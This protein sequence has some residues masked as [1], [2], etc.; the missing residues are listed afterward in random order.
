MLLSLLLLGAPSLV[1]IVDVN[2]IPMDREGVLEHQTV[3]VRGSRIAA[4][5]P[6]G[7]TQVPA[8]ATR[9]SG[10]GKY[11]MPGLVD[12][13][14]HLYSL[15]ELKMNLV[16]GI[17]T[18]YNL[19]GR[20]AH[21]A[22]RDRITKGQL[23]GPTIVTCGP[24]IYECDTAADAR[25]RVEAMAKRGYDA[26]KIYNDVS[27]EAFPALIESARSRH[28]LVVGHIPRAPGFDDTLKY[29]VPIAHA[30]EFL[31][32]VFNDGKTGPDEIPAVAKRTVDA[33]VSVTA[34]LVT[35]DHI[36]RQASDLKGLLARPATQ[37]LAP[38]R[39]E[40]WQ[41][42]VN[43]YEQRFKDPKVQ[44]KLAANLRFQKALIREIHKIGGVVL[45]GTDANCPGSVPGFELAEEIRN[46]GDCGFTPYEALKAATVDAAFSLGKRDE[47]GAVRAGQQADLL[48]LD[49]NPL[50]DLK[51]LESPAGVVARGQW[52]SR[53]RLIRMQAEIKSDYEKERRAGWA[54]LHQDP[55]RADKFFA[56]ND[57]FGGLSSSLI[58]R[59]SVSEGTAGYRRFYAR[60]K[61]SAP[62][63]EFISESAV[64]DMGYWWLKTKNSPKQAVDIFALNTEEHPDSANAW[65][66]LGE[67]YATAGDRDKA[68]ASYRRAVKLDPKLE[69]SIEALKKLGG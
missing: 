28:M 31:Y 66:S 33:G 5:G 11:L 59:I 6:V 46:L 23:L 16:N 35:Y 13:H 65:D 1:A 56:D 38:W 8:G 57:P 55:K 42:G 45:A 51:N 64:N 15:P 34:T 24:T 49:A 20:P 4:V 30:E 2:V 40:L 68:I 37:F 48:L 12:M 22:W 32:T 63:S 62:K 29:K 52:L 41:P 69:S 17:T 58:K 26:I 61:K 60:F 36:Y 21:L 3:V 54:I 19:N 39:A 44:Q 67:A 47:F 14:V 18:V 10:A 43:T 27:K 9:V 7:N 25:Q 53:D 50:S